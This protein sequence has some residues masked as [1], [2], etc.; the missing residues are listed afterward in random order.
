MSIDVYWEDEAQTI[1][2]WEFSEIWTWD[3]FRVAFKTSLALGEH[4]PYRVDVIADATKTPHMPLGA[5]AEFKRLDERLPEN[6]C[7]I[8]VAGTSVFTR[9]MIEVFSKVYR[10][11]SWRTATSIAEA[12]QLIQK[13]RQIA[14]GTSL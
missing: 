6:T 1:I 9:T 7:L 2:Y 4:L 12:R 8:V 10:A 14:L 13:D 3:E 11:K 5:L